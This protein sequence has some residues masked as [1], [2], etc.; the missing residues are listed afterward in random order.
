MKPALKVLSDNELKEV[1]KSSL[2]IL[3]KTGMLIDHK[4]ARDILQEA[5]AK[6]DH[7]KK[8][9]KFPPDLVEERLKMVPRKLVRH[10]RTPEY[11]VTLQRGGEIYARVAGG[12]TGYID[13]RSGEHRR[14]RLCDWKELTTLADALPTIRSI[15]TM[16]CGDVPEKIADIYSLHVLLENQRKNIVHNAFSITNQRYMIEMMVAV[17]GS[18][19]ALRKSPLVH[20]MLSPISPLFLNEDDTAQLLLA[21]EYGI[22]TDMPIMPTAGT[23]G[24]ITIAGTL[25]LANA[26][27]LGTMTLAQTVNPNHTM[28]YFLDPLVADMRTCTPLFGAPEVGLLVAA[29]AQMGCDLYGLPA[30][31]IGL[32]SDGFVAEQS[33]FQK[34]QNTLMLCLAGG[35]L[36]IGAGIVEATMALSPTQ[37]VIDDEIVLIARRLVR[38]IEVNEDTLA[39]EVINRVGPRNHFLEDIHTLKHIKTGELIDSSLFQR[40]NREAWISMGQKDIEQNA[41]EKAI[42]ILEK[43]EVE[44]LPDEV[45]R[46]LG[47][48][49]GRAEK[50]LVQ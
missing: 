29:I 25:A 32:D 39:V 40:C 6:V 44:P 34:A 37:L 38:G 13:L 49:I 27:Y 2:A 41:R 19:E 10:G 1:H 7:E 31:G 43:H 23:T 4:K 16:H 42:D 5:G 24:P 26:E 14:A 47:K 48:I 11:D 30:E 9:V 50:E 28:P 36:N 17:R 21:C 20:H 35:T 33:L 45:S 3:E 15:A 46:E 22:P 18:K 8:I 12:A